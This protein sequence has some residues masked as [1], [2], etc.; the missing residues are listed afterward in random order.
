MSTS[1]YKYTYYNNNYVKICIMYNTT[2]MYVYIIL[3][4]YV[5]VYIY[6]YV[7]ICMYMYMCMYMYVY[8]YVMYVYVYIHI[9][10]TIRFCHPPKT[11]TCA[12]IL[13]RSTPTSVRDVLPRTMLEIALSAFTRTCVT[14][15]RESVCVCVCA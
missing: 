9:L 8:V 15:E 1:I 5:Y 2:Y 7:C 3:H 14:R 10:C 13:P 4:M 6:T 11:Y 12:W